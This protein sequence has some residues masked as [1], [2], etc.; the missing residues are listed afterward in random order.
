[1]HAR[2]CKKQAYHVL[3]I[4]TDGEITDK[5]ETIKAIVEASHVRTGKKRQEGKGRDGRDGSMGGNRGGN[6]GNEEELTRPCVVC[7]SR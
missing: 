7:R 4:L 5:Q 2:E 3:L 1:M 6:V